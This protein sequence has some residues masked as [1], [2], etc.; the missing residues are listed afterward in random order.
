VRHFAG[1]IA[2][3]I[4]NAPEMLDFHK[5]P[6]SFFWLLSYWLVSWMLIIRE[7][8]WVIFNNAKLLIKRKVAFLDVVL[9]SLLSDGINEER[10]QTHN[11]TSLRKQINNLNKEPMCWDHR[12]WRMLGSPRDAAITIKDMMA[13]LDL[14]VLTISRGNN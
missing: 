13:H 12:Q 5:E 6:M 7:K 4:S 9:S 8:W 11:K 10:Q 3:L 14:A 1:P 2:L